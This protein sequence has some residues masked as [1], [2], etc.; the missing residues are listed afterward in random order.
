MKAKLPQKNLDH[1]QLLENLKS[2]LKL[3]YSLVAKVNRKSHKNNKRYYDRKAKPRQFAIDDLVYLF[4][5]ACKP[6]LTRKFYKPWKGA[7]RVTKKMSDLNYQI[8]D[9]HG[10]TQVVHL[11]RL[12]NHM[13]LNFGLPS[14]SV[15]WRESRPKG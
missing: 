4:N 3:A 11:N 12:R 7:Y 9:Q 6:G 15:E 1:E 10:K 2:S 13:V 8:T 14:K 5:P